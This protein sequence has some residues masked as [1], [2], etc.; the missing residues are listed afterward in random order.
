[1]YSFFIKRRKLMRGLVWIIVLAAICYLGWYVY[2]AYMMPETVTVVEE[3]VAVPMQDV[4][5]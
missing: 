1:M 3:M 4:Q 5:P 2:E